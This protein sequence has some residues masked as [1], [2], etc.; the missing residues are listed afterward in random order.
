MKRSKRMLVYYK[1][2]LDDEKARV[3]DVIKKLL[4]QTYIMERIYDKKTDRYLVNE[5]YRICERHM[6]FLKDYF[7]VADIDLLENRQYNIIYIKSPTLQG[8]KISQLSTY[9]ILLLKVIYDEQMST[10]SNS[11]QVYTNL[12]MINEKMQL[13]RLW[14][15]KLPVTEL[16]KTIAFLKRY[17]I[18]EVID[19]VSE[20]DSEIRFIINPIINLL[21]DGKDILEVIKQYQDSEEEEDGQQIFGNDKIMSE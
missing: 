6:E 9:F 13:F 2:L 20:L 12:G 8:E 19:D 21:F 3:T 14:K 10:V 7:S 5:D 16:R 4:S 11:I 18:V 17:Q 1:G 15:G